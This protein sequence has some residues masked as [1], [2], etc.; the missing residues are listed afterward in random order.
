[1][2]KGRFTAFCVYNQ[3]GL[4]NILV[5]NVLQNNKFQTAKQ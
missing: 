2:F 4:R 3:I 5:L 1:M